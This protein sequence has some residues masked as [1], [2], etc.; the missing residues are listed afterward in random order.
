MVLNS[1]TRERINQLFVLADPSSTQCRN[2]YRTT[3][4][5]FKS[6][7]PA[8]IAQHV[9]IALSHRVLAA[10][11]PVRVQ[12]W[13]GSVSSASKAPSRRPT[14]L[15]AEGLNSKSLD[16]P[17]L[18]MGSNVGSNSGGSRLFFASIWINTAQTSYTS[19][20][21][22]DVSVPSN[23]RD[24]PKPV[25]LANGASMESVSRAMFSLVTAP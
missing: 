3:C 5:V 18:T 25:N 23:L 1:K 22:C 12:L 17:F 11:V 16:I 24:L 10:F 7:Y 4:T 6:N 15:T 8:Q 9:P 19:T 20:P 21:G 2:I 14:R 13:S